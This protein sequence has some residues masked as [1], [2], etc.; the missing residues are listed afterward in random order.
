MTKP[1]FS[2]YEKRRAEYHEEIC[3][4][5]S[6]MVHIAS[7][8]C[9]LRCCRRNRV[10]SGPMMPSPHQAWTVRAQREIGLSGSACADLPACIALKPP[11]YYAPYREVM[12]RVQE[13]QNEEP[14]VDLLEIIIRTAAK[15]RRSPHAS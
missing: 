12:T 8:F 1:D 15:R 5:A 13:M 14:L 2:D 11:E 4:L 9:R 7:G 6:T 10:C 3:R